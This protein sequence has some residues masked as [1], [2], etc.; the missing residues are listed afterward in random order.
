[1]THDGALT[2][3]P[4]GRWLPLPGWRG[5]DG[6]RALVT[7]PGPLVSET[8]HALLERGLEV[9]VATDTPDAEVRDLAGR[10]LVTVVPTTGAELDQVDLVVRD[11][12][13]LAPEETA[14]SLTTASTPPGEVVLVGGGPGST[15]L[16]TLD[17][18]EALRTA[19]VVV[20]DRLAPLGA[21]DLAP[22]SAERVPVGKIPRG[23]FTPQEVINEVLVSRSLQGRRVVRLKGGD[24]FVF[25]RGGE[26]WLACAAAG[27]PVRV[28]PGVTSAVAVPG[29][30]GI[31]VTHRDVTPGFV[32]VSGHVGP[33]DPRNTVDWAAL[34]A[35]GL[36]I[37]VLMGVS[38]LGSIARR[39]VEHGLPGTTP[40]AVV[41]DGAMPSQRSVRGDLLTIA[42]AADE[43]GICAPAVAVIGRTVGVLD[44]VETGPA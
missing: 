34:A 32:V 11:R 17:G 18:A 25:G 10:G 14:A 36:T 23:E 2:S 16:L 24:S 43:A 33:D 19:D 7:H 21:L 13:G 31:P 39:L 30:A 44:Q 5:A 26:E 1:M 29:L 42:A 12:A 6:L 28:V 8:V 41:A 22:A 37:V 3:G 35:S 9:S 40:A 15:G 20:Y 27:V 38:T 4:D